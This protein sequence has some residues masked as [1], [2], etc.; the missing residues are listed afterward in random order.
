M[1]LLFAIAAFFYSLAGHGGAS[2]YTPLALASGLGPADA[3]SA[4]L[5]LNLLVS[6]MAGLAFGLAGQ[7]R[8]RM[9]LPLL[10]GA[11]PLVMLGSRLLV[12][13]PYINYG[14]GFAM[15]WAAWRFTL[16]R[17]SKS[18]LPALETPGFFV[19]IM[20]GAALGLLSGLTGVGG[21]IYLSPLLLFKRWV[22]ARE[23]AALAACFIW[24]NSGVSLAATGM[25]ALPRPEWAAACFAGG[26]LGSVLGARLATP[27]FLR[28]AL[29]GVLLFAAFKTLV[30]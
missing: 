2:A 20:I 11:A 16:G 10:L 22:T 23:A 9:A 19:L 29:G 25:G 12:K 7:L 18:D 14:L 15:L 4:A 26:M 28:R 1:S 24:F 30:N 13:S 3:R 27:I 17:E 6:G 5:L 8:I 21:G